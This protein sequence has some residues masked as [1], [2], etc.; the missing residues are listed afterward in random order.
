GIF[1]FLDNAGNAEVWGAELALTMLPLD[2]LSLTTSVTW[3]DARLQNDYDPGNG[4]PPAQKGDRLPGSP[5]WSASNT[6]TASWDSARWQPTLTLI[7]RYE[8]ESA[9]NLL[10]QDIPKGGYHL[11][12]LRAGVRRGNVTLTAFG[13][14]LADERGVTASN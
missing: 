8:G 5:E 1:K 13:K 12:D 4:R 11:F 10:Y 14:N 7:H 3:L 2:F 6:L 9:S